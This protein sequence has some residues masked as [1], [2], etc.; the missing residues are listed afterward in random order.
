MQ[1]LFVS[2]VKSICI[3]KERKVSSCIG[4]SKATSVE[5][6]EEVEEE[7]EKK[8]TGNLLMSY[9]HGASIARHHGAVIHTAVVHMRMVHVVGVVHVGVIHR[10]GK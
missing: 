9:I 7:D 6:V 8:T 5:E 1:R 4:M 3:D 2:Q 10:D